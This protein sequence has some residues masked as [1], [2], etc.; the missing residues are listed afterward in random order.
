M[1]TFSALGQFG[2]FAN[3][4]FQYAFLRSVARVTGAQYQAPQWIGQ[5]LFD[6]DDPP[7]TVHLRPLIENDPENNQLFHVVPEMRRYLEKI[8]GYQSIPVTPAA[9][10]NGLPSGDLIGFFQ[11]HS[12]NYLPHRDFLRQIFRPA[13]SL[14]DWVQEPVE[15]LRARGRTV[16][17][18]H[19]R[20]GEYRW[21]PQL[22]Y[23]LITPERWW[24]DW[25]EQN[26]SSLNDPVLYI[27]SDGLDRVIGAFRKYNPVSLRDL[28]MNTPREV[29]GL[30]A[31]FYRDYHVLTQA[32]VV[33]VSNSSFSFSACMLNE[34][35]TRFVRPTWDPEEHLVDFDPW[36]SEVKLNAVNRDGR[37]PLLSVLETAYDWGGA[38]EVLKT[39]FGYL[40]G[41]YTRI[42]KMRVP[43]AWSLDGWRGVARALMAN[44]Q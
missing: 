6:L 35:G 3:Q 24:V 16:V 10:R 42:T 41:G 11:C 17:A 22:P 8:T 23:S 34:R 19:L 38:T 43:I 31:D 29:A 44:G 15:L 2:R 30:D 32:D 12:S 13:S 33:G 5:R 26:W 36:N 7:V 40:P 1:L 9:L 39:F 20:R 14:V 25:L 28:R 37:R 21:V 4:L 18:I 27:C